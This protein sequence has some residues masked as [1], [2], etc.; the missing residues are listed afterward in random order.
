MG[1][2]DLTLSVKESTKAF[3]SGTGSVTFISPVNVML[4]VVDVELLVAGIC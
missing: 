3:A 2:C 1:Y 4:S